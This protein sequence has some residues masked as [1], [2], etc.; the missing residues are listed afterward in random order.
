MDKKIFGII[1]FIL[2]LAFFISYIAISSGYYEYELQHRMVLTSEA[3]KK[4][5]EDVEEGKDVSLEEYVIPNSKDYTNTLTNSTNKVAL[6][7]N[8]A[9]KKGIEKIFKVIGNFVED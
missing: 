6:G 1:F 5:E 2:F 8:N 7:V 4:F 9:L 3:M